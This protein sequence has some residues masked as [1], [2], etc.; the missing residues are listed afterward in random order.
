[1]SEIYSLFDTLAAVTVPLEKPVGGRTYVFSWSDDSHKNDWRC[2]GYRWRQSGT[3]AKKST[4]ELKRVYFQVL[5]V[6]GYS[7]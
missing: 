6:I 2:D 3:F 1:M 4:G 7:K 5:Y